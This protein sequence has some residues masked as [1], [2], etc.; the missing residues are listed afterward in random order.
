M[1]SSYLFLLTYD[2][3]N[4]K[5]YD[6]EYIGL[7]RIIRSENVEVANIVQVSIIINTFF[8]LKFSLELCSHI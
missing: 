4:G 2:I 7:E 3:L 6:Y 5:H 1:I 8:N